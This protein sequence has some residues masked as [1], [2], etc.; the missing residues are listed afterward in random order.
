MIP[1]MVRQCRE[2]HS[3]IGTA[4]ML[5]ERLLNDSQSIYYV[6]AKEKRTEEYRPSASIIKQGSESAGFYVF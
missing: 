4:L 3:C 1:R 6:C 2:F 5:V